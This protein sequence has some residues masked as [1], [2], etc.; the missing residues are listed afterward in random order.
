MT[1]PDKRDEL[2]AFLRNHP[3]YCTAR[4]GR[5]EQA[6]DTLL[7]DKQREKEL[8]ELLEEAQL[9]FALGVGAV[10]ENG[11]RENQERCIREAGELN[12]RISKYLTG[13]R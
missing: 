1:S 6:A 9:M 7:A 5:F 3:I 13:I 4:D 8:T 2:A 11:D 12:L 10:T